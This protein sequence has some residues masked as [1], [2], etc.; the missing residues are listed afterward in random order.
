[1]SLQTIPASLTGRSD[2]DSAQSDFDSIW[3]EAL[4]SYQEETGKNV[5]E[6]PFANKLLSR[7]LATDEVIQYI[8]EQNESFDSFRTSGRKV[9]SVLKP[10]VHVVH[11]FIDAG[12]EGASKVAPGG[13]AILVA[14]GVLL[15]TAKGISA[16][17]DA[18][19]ALLRK[20]SACLARTKVYLETSSPPN[21]ALMDVLHTIFVQVFIVLGI[22]TKY[23]DKAS[24]KDS[25]SKGKKGV[26]AL[27]QRIRDYSCVFLGETDVQ[28]A[29]E[30]LEELAEEEQLM[31]SADTN[32]VIRQGEVD[33]M[34]HKTGMGRS[35]LSI[36]VTP[37][38]FQLFE[39][40]IDDL[41]MWLDPPN[42]A[43]INYE[44][45]RLSSS[46][47]WFF[48]DEFEGWKAQKGGMYWVFG[49]AGAGKSIICSSV[50]DTLRKDPELLLAYFYFDEGDPK[51]Q[52]CRGLLSSL[53]FQLGTSSERGLDYLKGQRSLH[54]LSCDELLPLLSQLLSLSGPTVIVID[55]LDECPERAREGL[56]KLIKHL[57]SLRSNDAVDLRVLVTSR[58]ENDIQSCLS[59][60][61]THT[62]NV[63]VAREHTEDIMNY[64]S[65]QLFDPESQSFSTWDEHVKWKAYNHLIWRSNGMFLWVVLQLQDLKHCGADDVER[66]LDELPS[67]LDG[68]YERIL[69][70]FPSKPA[71]VARAL[72]RNN[73][74]S[75]LRFSASTRGFHT[76]HAN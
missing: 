65:T 28:E 26:R 53:V 11:L 45:K 69:K 14:V 2:D 37:V 42:P 20:I 72:H 41:R 60:I 76:R 47:G 18:I 17:Y 59:F 12:A 66:A 29:L 23:C 15:Q 1:M 9:L 58:P 4:R 33:Y 51:K 16:L 74:F 27:K 39:L 56:L 61:A 62:L 6:L 38:S 50:I 34:Y 63:N 7:P 55:A 75:G 43:P 64:I 19:E 48:D 36:S 32:A 54:T 40:V 13:K 68:T 24:D 25:K 22:V 21:P 71:M 44:G 30:E 10:I 67:D 57:H 31:A 49:H 35:F 70:R 46:C 5:L 73:P 8:G 3:N 52:H